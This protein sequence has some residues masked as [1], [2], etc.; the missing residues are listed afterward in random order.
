VKPI[1]VLAPLVLALS[2][3]CP[4]Q[5]ESP[6]GLDPG[7]AAVPLSA[8]EAVAEALQANPEIR[9]AVRRLS[10]AQLKTGTARSLDDP[11]LMMRDWDTPLLKPWDLNQAQLMVSLQQT[12]PKPA[13]AGL[14]RKAGGGRCRRGGHRFGN[15]A[16]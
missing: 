11:M 6:S 16:P 15:P 4:G 9:A 13:E 2:I 7:R 8:D 12:F 5:A 3:V 10:L 14:A 1:C